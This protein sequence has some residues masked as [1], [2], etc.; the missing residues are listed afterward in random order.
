MYDIHTDTNQAGLM[1]CYIWSFL[2]GSW[3]SVGCDY[4]ESPTVVVRLSPLN[5]TLME[6]KVDTGVV[7]GTRQKWDDNLS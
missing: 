7:R 2:H 1:L 6:P 5:A 4:R 3:R